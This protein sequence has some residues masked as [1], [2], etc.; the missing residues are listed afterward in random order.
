MEVHD[1]KYEVNELCI[2]CGLCESVCPEIFELQDGVA[3]AKDIEV[4]NELELAAED[5]C[6]GCPVAAIERR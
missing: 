6:N 2:G 1:M 5:A 4:P 3:V